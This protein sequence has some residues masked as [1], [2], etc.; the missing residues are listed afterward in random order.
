MSR[1]NVEI[2]LGQWDAW[3][4]GDLARW[5]QAFDPEVVVTAPKGWPDGPVERGLDAWRRQAQRLRDTWA[6]ARV[7]P[8]EIWDVED[9]VLARFRYVTLGADTGIPFDTPMAVV[10]FLSERKITRGYFGWTMGEALE[11]AGL[12]E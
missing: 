3:N 6:E 4:S 8:D 11:A 5:A 1:E 2:I 10:F 9:R 7:E 12:G